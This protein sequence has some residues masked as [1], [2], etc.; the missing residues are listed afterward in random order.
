MNIII[1]SIFIVLLS[2]IDGISQGIDNEPY[3]TIESITS[4]DEKIELTEHGGSGYIAGAI[5]H[6]V[7]INSLALT[8]Y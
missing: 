4:E 6:A 1:V 7:E 3:F 8:Y 5:E 2:C